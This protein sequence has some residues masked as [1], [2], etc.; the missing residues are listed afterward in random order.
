MRNKINTAIEQIKIKSKIDVTLARINAILMAS[1]HTNQLDEVIGYIDESLN[2][3]LY[4][5]KDDET[6]TA[7]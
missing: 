1:V 2:T 5:I 6:E 7:E 4:S 3:A